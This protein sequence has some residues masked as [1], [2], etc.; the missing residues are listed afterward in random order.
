VKANALRRA[1]LAIKRVVDIAMS[2]FLLVFLLPLMIAI[3]V[4]VRAT[5]P[6]AVIFRQRRVGK[7]GRLFV[8]YKFRTMTQEASTPGRGTRVYDDD[9]RITRVGKFLRRTSLDELPQ[10]FNVM[11]GEMSFVGPRPDLPHHVEAYTEFQRRRLE[12]RP[13]ITGWAQVSG[14]NELTWDERIMLDAEYIQSWSLARDLFVVMK[15]VAVVLG[16]KGVALPRNVG[17]A[18]DDKGKDTT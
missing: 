4:A 1:Q 11:K 14:R 8:I 17:D 5:S 16:R 18:A 10:L 15:T 6:G 7:G 9:P 3:A 13:G 2:A 12:V